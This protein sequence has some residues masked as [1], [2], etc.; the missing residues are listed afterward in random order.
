MVE[1]DRC[2]TRTVNPQVVAL[3]MAQTGLADRVEPV[4]NQISTRP[5]DL[6]ANDADLSSTMSGTC[7]RTAAQLSVIA[8]SGWSCIF[9]PLRIWIVDL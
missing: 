9:D 5:L 7:G 1:Q 6:F 4:P 3:P 2:A 8:Q